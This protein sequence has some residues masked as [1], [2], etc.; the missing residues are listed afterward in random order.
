LKELDWSQ[1]NKL[2]SLIERKIEYFEDLAR[3]Q[4]AKS[5]LPEGVPDLVYLN[6]VREYQEFQS[7]FN[8]TWEEEDRKQEALTLVVP[9]SDQL[10]TVLG[11]EPIVA[12]IRQFLPETIEAIKAQLKGETWSVDDIGVLR[13]G[14]LD[15]TGVA[16][17][18]EQPQ[19]TGD[20]ITQINL[21]LRRMVNKIRQKKT[22]LPWQIAQTFLYGRS[23]A[24]S[25][26]KTA[27]DID[28]E[29][30][31]AVVEVDLKQAG[32]SPFKSNRANGE[33]A[34]FHWITQLADTREVAKLGQLPTSVY[35]CYRQ[36]LKSKE[37]LNPFGTWG[38]ESVAKR[39]A[40][41]IGRDQC[42]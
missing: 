6:V 18:K 38:A 27:M 5:K 36:F 21:W 35:I 25:L 2:S 10:R 24:C 20:E 15:K 3:K 39:A 31:A 37:G 16:E 30:R 12:A 13:M 32:S 41:R 26:V 22:V 4:Q 11:E 14:Y 7:R 9:W 40:L 17:L 28:M 29:I 8:L 33:N 19:P 23:G 34:V 42:K 1:L